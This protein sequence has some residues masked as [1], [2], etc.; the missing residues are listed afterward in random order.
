MDRAVNFHLGDLGSIP[1]PGSFFALFIFNFFSVSVLLRDKNIINM[2]QWFSIVNTMQ[3]S[4]WGVVVLYYYYYHVFM[5]PQM[6]LLW[7]VEFRCKRLHSARPK[8]S[9][10]HANPSQAQ[11]I[12]YYK[13]F[14]ES[15]IYPKFWECGL[16]VGRSLQDRNDIYTLNPTV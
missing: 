6:L 5:V 7:S 10:G 8:D 3:L 16:F 14:H 4:N 1:A 12:T 2:Q 9:T 15:L 13:S 11:S